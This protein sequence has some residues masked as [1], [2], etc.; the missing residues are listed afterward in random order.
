MYANIL[1]KGYPV[2]DGVLETN[3]ITFARF[4]NLTNCHTYGV[5]AIG[6]NPIS[7]DAVH[8]MQLTGSTRLNTDKQS[9]A[10]YYPPDPAWIVQEVMDH[11]IQRCTT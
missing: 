8:P 3:N 4:F 9:I 11:V 2:I 10:H 6:N 5:Y 1:V 7:P